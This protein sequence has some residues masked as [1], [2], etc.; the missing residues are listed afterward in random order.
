VSPSPALPTRSPWWAP[1]SALLV[2]VLGALV[3]AGFPASL[4]FQAIGQSRP[5]GW[6]EMLGCGL[7]GLAVLWLARASWLPGLAAMAARFLQ[8]VEAPSLGVILVLGVALRVALQWLIDPSPASDGAAYVSLAQG[9]IERGEYGNDAVRAYWPPGMAFVLVPLLAVAPLPLALGVYTVVCF[10]LAALGLYRLGSSLGLGAHAKW[11]PMLLAVWPTHALMSGLPEKE[12]LV[13]ALLPWILWAARQA[14]LTAGEGGVRWSSA[15]VCGLLLGA[16]VLL[17]PSFQLLPPFAAVLALIAG[18]HWRSV[19][20]TLVVVCIG[21]AVVIAPWTLRNLS[22][23]GEP[24]LVSTN[25]GGNLYRVNNELAT[26]AYLA[27][28]KIDVEALP[29][30]E[31]NREGKRLAVEWI[32]AH[33]WDFLQLTAGRVLLFPGDHSGGAYAAFRADPERLPRAAYLVLKAGTAA[34]WLALWGVLL[35]SAWVY[36]KGRSPVPAGALLLLVPWLYLSGIH[37]IFESGSKYHLPALGVVLLMFVL[38]LQS[39]PAGTGQPA[40]R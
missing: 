10:V 32:K 29:E 7:A 8:R 14:C 5:L 22:V 33:P 12:L 18:Q 20:G 35:A 34:T 25:G 19:L 28:G 15:L 13:I 27:V 1:W 36:W 17:Q 9:L 37:A 11:P 30:L 3:F 16:V 31:A 2:L 40:R 6:L 4:V 23:L 39:M 24:V 21:A 26:G 38:M